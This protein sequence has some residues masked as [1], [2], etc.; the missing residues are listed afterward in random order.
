L[1]PIE[2]YRWI[3]NGDVF[4]ADSSSSAS[5]SEGRRDGDT[6]QVEPKRE[7]EDGMEEAEQGMENGEEA[8]EEDSRMEESGE[9]GAE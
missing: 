7:E 9:T 1:I 5:G 3:D 4:L 6:V 8:V 2:G